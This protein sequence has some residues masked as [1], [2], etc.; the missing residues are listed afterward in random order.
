[1]PEFR[2][3]KE[4]NNYLKK[5]IADSMQKAGEVAERVVREH[6]DKDVYQAYKPE[7]YETTFEL[8]ESLF[9]KTPKIKNDTIEVEVKHNTDL[10]NSHEPNQH[11]SVVESYE[12]QDVSDWIPYIV[13][14]GKTANIWGDDPNTAYLKPRPYFDNAREEL[15]QSKEHVEALKNDLRRKGINVE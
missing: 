8:R 9:T 10:I 13:H 5:Q 7:Q 2:S 11:H 3:I 15:E 1:M 6:V 14:N 12:P 4:L